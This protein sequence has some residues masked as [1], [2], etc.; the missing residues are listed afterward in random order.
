MRFK[1]FL[2]VRAYKCTYVRNEMNKLAIYINGNWEL[3][4]FLIYQRIFQGGCSILYTGF[5]RFTRNSSC[6][7][8]S[9]QRLH[10]RSYEVLAWYHF[11]TVIQLSRCTGEISLKGWLLKRWFLYV[12]S[13]L[14][15]KSWKFVALHKNALHLV[16][17]LKAWKNDFL[18]NFFIFVK[19]AQ[20][21]KPSHRQH[22]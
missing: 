16:G 12:F 1:V 14:F 21:K 8:I 5:C 3:K 19:I 11:R 17:I 22:K 10:A 6:P 13:K 15:S 7:G 18:W 2:C 4:M 9:P 20:Q